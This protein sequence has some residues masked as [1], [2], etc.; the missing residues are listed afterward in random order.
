MKETAITVLRLH[1]STA[2]TATVTG[3]EEDLMTT[4]TFW[5][6]LY[7]PLGIL[8]VGVTGNVLSF[9]LLSQNQY[10]SSS[11]CFYMKVLAIF[12]SI[13]L[14][15]WTTYDHFKI[16]TN[17]FLESRTFICALLNSLKRAIPAVSSTLL[18]TMSVDRFLAVAVPLKARSWCN[19]G[20]AKIA[21]S[22]IIGLLLAIHVPIPFV[23]SYKTLEED[24]QLQ[25]SVSQWS[26]LYANFRLVTTFYIPLIVLF[27]SNLCI[28][29]F[30]KNNRRNMQKLQG[31][32][33]GQNTQQEGHITLMLLAV[34][35]SSFVFL[36]PFQVARLYYRYAF[37]GPITQKS[38]TVF[39]FI[40]S[41]T[42]FFQYCNYGMNFY[43][44]TL[45]IAK[46][47]RE[48]QVMIRCYKK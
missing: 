39:D 14:I 32:D 33:A 38:R 8:V 23:R 31:V 37:T 5:F 29:C 1:L 4:L 36:I 42:G 44:Y 25:G 13:F 19:V 27:I 48:L 47:R 9:L 41:F 10:K 2:D 15:T 12:D 7:A 26:H 11:T 3:K 35:A 22:L 6:S 46:F 21:T 30:V 43:A 40:S 17:P 34:T 20:R 18:T 28:V 24:C 16:W 45:P